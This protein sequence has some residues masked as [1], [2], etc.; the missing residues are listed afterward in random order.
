MIAA[1]RAIAKLE[2]NLSFISTPCV[3]VAAIVVSEI[4]DKLS[5]NMAP[6]IVAATTRYTFRPPASASPMAIGVTATTVPTDVPVEIPMNPEIT[7]TPAATNCGGRTDMPRFTTAST[8]PI[9]LDT[10]VNAP[11]NKKIKHIVIT[12]V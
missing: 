4:I 8:P 3:R 11:A 5:P 12:S 7:N 6:Q 2:R 10:V 9:S 1:G